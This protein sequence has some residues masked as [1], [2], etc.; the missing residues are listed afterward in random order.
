MSNKMPKIQMPSLLGT[1]EFQPSP[2][3]MQFAVA[4]VQ[5]ENTGKSPHAVLVAMGHAGQNW[6]RWEKLPY[7]SQ[8]LQKTTTEFMGTTGLADIYRAMYREGMRHSAQDRKLML[9]R[10]DPSYKPASAVDLGVGQFEGRRPPDRDEMEAKKRRDA[11]IAAKIKAINEQEK[12]AGPSQGLLALLASGEVTEED[13]F[14]DGR[15]PGITEK[16]EAKLKDNM[17][18]ERGS[19]N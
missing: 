9:E 1:A 18:I 5:F 16:P 7:F 13:V 14:P 4:W 8:W 6:Y 19:L 15:P 17:S 12:K 10:F 11:R 3:M 2:L